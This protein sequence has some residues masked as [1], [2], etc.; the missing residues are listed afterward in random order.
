MTAPEV[1]AKC[2]ANNLAYMR[3]TPAGR[4]GYG[5]VVRLYERI[6]S[7]SLDCARAWEAGMPC[8]PHEPVV[9][10]FWW[11]VAAWANVFCADVAAWF[12]PV[13]AG[14]IHNGLQES[15][16]C[17]H[18]EFAQWLRPEIPGARMVA[19]YS[20]QVVGSSPAGI[21]LGH[22]AAWTLLVI[23]LTARWGLL[24]HLKDLP[25][26]WQSLRLVRRLRRWPDPVAGAYL[27]SDVAFLREMFGHFD[28][29]PH[30]RLALDRFLESAEE[31]LKHVPSTGSG[32][33]LSGAEEPGGRR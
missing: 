6:A 10:A 25:A 8:P 33:A 21:I 31:E 22:D 3:A 12:G 2:A 16:C 13:H 24:R 4:A 19:C 23:R 15:F 9:D 11:G 7:Q 26:L 27:E 28:F 32:Q 18:Q 14:I 1:M 20:P 29:R 30:V 5:A 17:P